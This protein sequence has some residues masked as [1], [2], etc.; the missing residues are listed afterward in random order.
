LRTLQAFDSVGAMLLL[1]FGYT[2][3]IQKHWDQPVPTKL[4]M[5]ECN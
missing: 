1:A 5:N 2:L 4:F 3:V